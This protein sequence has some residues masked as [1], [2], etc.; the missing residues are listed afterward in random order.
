MIAGNETCFQPSHSGVGNSLAG[1]NGDILPLARHCPR[2]SYFSNI[3]QPERAWKDVD[4]LRL[5]RNSGMSIEDFVH[6][7]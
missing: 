7:E 6:N 1:N 3:F 4:W 2:N 5:E